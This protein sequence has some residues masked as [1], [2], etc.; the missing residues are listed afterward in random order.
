MKESTK[1]LL[2]LGTISLAV[3]PVASMVSCAPVVDLEKPTPVVPTEFNDKGFRIHKD[4]TILGLSEENNEKQLQIPSKFHYTDSDGSITEVIA[5]AIGSNAFT[6]RGLTSVT[7]PNSVTI[8]GDQAFA[9]NQLT[10]VTIPDSIT[11]IEESAFSFNRLISITIP[12]SVTT[13]GDFAFASNQLTS[14]TIPDSITT[15]E[16]SSFSSNQLTSI[17]I[18]NSVT[19][20]GSNAFYF[21]QLTSI[22]IPNSVTTIGDFAFANHPPIDASKLNIP[23]QFKTPTELE[24]IGIT[25]YKPPVVPTEFNDKGF[26]IHKDGIILGLSEGNNEKQLQI[27]SKFHYTHSDG[28]ITEV[29]AHTI[30]INAFTMRGL[31]SV[32]IPN[33][34]TTIGANSFYYNQLTSITIP[35]SVTTIEESA[36]SNNQLTSITIPDSVTTIGDFAFA[37]NPPIDA[38]KLNI[39]TQFKTPTELERIGITIYKPPVVPTE[40]N[41]KGFR[42]HK[43]GIILGLSEGNNEKQ[44]QIPSKFHYTHP[45]GSITEVIAHTIGNK[46]FFN[47]QLTSI[48]IPDSVT[49]I[50]ESAFSHNSQLTSV[51][52][53][54]SVTTI[55]GWAFYSNQLTSIIIPKSVTTIEYFAFA[56]NQLTSIIIPNSVTTI[57]SNVFYLNQLTSIIIPDS[58]TII[59]GH[60]FANNRLTSITIPNSV[61]TIGDFAFEGNPPI[62]ASKLNI[63]AQFKTPT[64]LSRIGIRLI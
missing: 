38:S 11:T 13:I 16:S 1:L 51:T 50:E 9:S 56:S 57:G 63:P 15:I 46:A 5:R 31:I 25:I 14:I 60:A 44:L 8:I 10:S 37:S 39:P 35:D 55:G 27:P 6:M 59:G 17:I 42:I 24:R 53:G 32:T 33:S 36:F 12:D 22:T 29:I 28:S 52:L 3:L 4:G 19:T 64:E 61:T 45:D 34:V 58:I 23:A 41:D 43:D 49:T 21:N 26:R 54:N 47:S 40:F 30:G 20:I 48:T 18:P 7:I 2:G 62:D